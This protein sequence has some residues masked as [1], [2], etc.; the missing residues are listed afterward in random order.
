MRK[1]KRKVAYETMKRMG[2]RQIN[3]HGYTGPAYERIIVPSYFAQNWRD[4]I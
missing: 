3:K 1:L 2:I 4:V